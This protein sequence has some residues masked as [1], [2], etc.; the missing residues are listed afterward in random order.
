GEL[1]ENERAAVEA[2]LEASDEAKLL[3]EELR[4]AANLTRTELRDAVAVPALTQEQRA[5]IRTAASLVPSRSWFGVRSTVWLSGAAALAAAI[6]LAVVVMPLQHKQM[7]TYDLPPAL[8][9]SNAT[10]ATSA[11]APASSQGESD[12]A[13]LAANSGL[14]YG[15]PAVESSK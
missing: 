2:E 5:T 3:V 14:R 1:D 12:Q 6:V 13:K 15:A 4:F 8:D 9:R 10:S 11:P 7:A